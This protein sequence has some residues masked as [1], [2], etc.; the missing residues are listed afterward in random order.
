MRDTRPPGDLRQS[1]ARIAAVRSFRWQDVVVFE[2]HGWA[3]V[4]ASPGVEDDEDADNR[5]TGILSAVQEYLNGQAPVVDE[6]LDWRWQNGQ[7]HVWVAGC[8]NH[9]T[10]EPHDVLTR[11]GLLA[12]GSY[13]VLHS[14]Y[15]GVDR[16]WSRRVL[17]RGAVQLEV[18][19]TLS[20]HVGEVEDPE[21]GAG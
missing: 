15:H 14:I 1:K 3:V 9:P 19:E 13:G 2:W 6:V 5:S 17:R 10:M 18:E 20:P 7:M 16:D 8:H 4:V 11:I 12:P 21:P